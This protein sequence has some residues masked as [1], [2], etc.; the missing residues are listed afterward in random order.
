MAQPIVIPPDGGNRA[1]F[2]GLGVHWKIFGAQTGGRF[3]VV[4][5]P[6]KPRALAAPLHRHR[7]E[8]E[9]SYVLD[10]T[11]GA[12]LGDEHVS[13]TVGTWVFKP[14]GQWHTFWNASDQPCH[15][16]ELISPAGFERYF[17]EL[18]TALG[19]AGRMAQVREKYELEVDI[20]SVPSLCERYGLTFP[21]PSANRP[22][23]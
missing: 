4:H 18:A 20:A 23:R 22:N 15:I 7:N 9:Y 1:D 6:L 19:N 13:A 17:E 8:D 12:L 16:I 5:H 3:A 2:G 14:R 10:G 11:M 21:M